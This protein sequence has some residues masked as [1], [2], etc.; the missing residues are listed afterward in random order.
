MANLA[1]LEAVLIVSAVVFILGSSAAAS[2][3]Q[4]GT[5]KGNDEETRFEEYGMISNFSIFQLLN[6]TL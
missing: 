3:R 5:V 6:P 2:D 4:T 1:R